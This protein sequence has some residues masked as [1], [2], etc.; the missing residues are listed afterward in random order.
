MGGIVGVGVGRDWRWGIV[1]CMG[2]VFFATVFV[3]SLFKILR[4]PIFL[5]NKILPKHPIPHPISISI[6]ISLYIFRIQTMALLS[7]LTDYIV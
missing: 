4:I 3:R 7:I 1:G 6:P 2:L 5:P